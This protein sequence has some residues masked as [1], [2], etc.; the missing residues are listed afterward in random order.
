[1]F[2]LALN[3]IFWVSIG[4]V[5]FLILKWGTEKYIQTFRKVEEDDHMQNPEDWGV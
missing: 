4:G 1:L 5:L 2:E 3:I